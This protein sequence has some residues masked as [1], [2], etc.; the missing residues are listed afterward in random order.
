MKKSDLRGGF[1]P[2]LRLALLFFCL[3]QLFAASATLSRLY[4]AVGLRYDAAPVTAAGAAAVQEYQRSAENKPT[5]SAAAP[6]C[7]S[8]WIER[9]APVTAGSAARTVAGVPVIGFTGNAAACYGAAYLTG[10]A[11]GSGDTGGCAL[12][13][14]LAQALYGSTDVAGLPLTLG[15]FDETG[16]AATALRTL[17]VRGVFAGKEPL[18]LCAAPA[19][20]T[21]TAVEL[22]N[23]NP[24]DPGRAAAAFAAAAG[25]PAASLTLYGPQLAA[26]AGG[27]CLLPLL[28]VGV[29]LLAGLWRQFRPRGRTGRA[30]LLFALA[31]LAALALPAAL[32]ALPG[33]LVPA[34]WSDFTF[35]SDLA[36]SAVTRTAEW[37][38]LLPHQKDLAAKA[39]LLPLLSAAIAALFLLFLP[40][41]RR[42]TA[43]KSAP[44]NLEQPIA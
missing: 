26:L 41:A 2:L 5:G 33:W 21:F 29:R 4:P 7:A 25:L 27:L 36:A 8:F 32:V 23:V 1:W 19:G 43:A 16:D 15:R 24:D 38:A 22:E 35:W 6:I 31:L 17:T 42:G 34:R 44:T 3:W 30:W 12:S 18:L 14:G 9:T 11:P 13:A 28:V 40:L 20:S 39:A 37:F 10:T